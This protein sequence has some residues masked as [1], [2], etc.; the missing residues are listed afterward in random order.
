M[1]RCTVWTKTRSLF[2]GGEPRCRRAVPG[3]DAPGRL[4]RLQRGRHLGGRRPGGRQTVP[5]DG[6]ER[7]SSAGSPRGRASIATKFLGRSGAAP[8]ARCMPPTTRTWIGGSRSRSCS[9]RPPGRRGR[10]PTGS[11][12]RERRARLLREARAIARLSHP[13]VVAVHDAGTVGE[14][15]YVAMEFVDGRRRLRG[16]PRKHALGRGWP[17]PSST[18]WKRPFGIRGWLAQAEAGIAV[19]EHDFKRARALQEEP[20]RLKIEGLGSEHRRPRGTFEPGPILTSWA[21][22]TRQSLKMTRRLACS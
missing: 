19:Q 5:L 15:V 12:S 20:L 17:K 16:D 4:R 1:R 21:Y 13:N 14:H 10:S 7:R 9:T 2:R 8:W 3:R 18:A 22:P 11:A 6:K